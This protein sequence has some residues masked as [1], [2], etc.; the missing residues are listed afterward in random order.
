[1][2]WH[3]KPYISSVGHAPKLATVATYIQF[4]A[5]VLGFGS[6]SQKHTYF[7]GLAL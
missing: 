6:G 2:I 1:M 3:S 4:R 7:F 5:T